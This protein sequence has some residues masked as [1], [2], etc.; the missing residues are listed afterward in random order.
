MSLETFSRT[1]T[2]IVTNLIKLGGLVVGVH[3]I[4][5]HSASPNAIV[6]AY[7]ALMMAGGQASETA[8]LGFIE[9]FFGVQRRERPK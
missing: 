1:V 2:L 8:V 7:S 4:F 3:E 5:V 6:L 9:R